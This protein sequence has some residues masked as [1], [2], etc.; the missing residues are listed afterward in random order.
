MDYTNGIFID[1]DPRDLNGLFE[2]NPIKVI[3][4]NRELKRLTAIRNDFK[5]IL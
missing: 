3:R 4:N 1:D 2:K 5:E